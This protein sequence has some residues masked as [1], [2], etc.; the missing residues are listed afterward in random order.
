MLLLAAGDDDNADDDDRIVFLAAVAVSWRHLEMLLLL[1]MMMVIVVVAISL[2]SL[3][4]PQLADRT[5]SCAA[6]NCAS[7]CPTAVTATTTAAVG[8]TVTKMGARDC[9]SVRTTASYNSP[10]H[11]LPPVRPARSPL[12]RL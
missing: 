7:V 2:S 3:F 5:S 6:I 4:L 12:P 8:P 9:L 11:P 1:L 10:S